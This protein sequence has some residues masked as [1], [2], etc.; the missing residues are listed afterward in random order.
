MALKEDLAPALQG[1]VMLSPGGPPPP[2]GQPRNSDDKHQV[3]L[4]PL[5][6]YAW[7][8]LH[9]STAILPPR[10]LTALYFLLPESDCL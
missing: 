5:L 4:N 6:D 2:N 10:F 8:C 3:S 1:M 9:P 7:F